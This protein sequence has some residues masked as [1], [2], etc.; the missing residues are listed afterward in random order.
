MRLFSRDRKP[1]DFEVLLVHSND[2]LLNLV[3]G[4]IAHTLRAKVS[5]GC[6]LV[7]LALTSFRS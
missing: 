7:V 6:Y 1:N 3:A 5:Q 4:A 2:L